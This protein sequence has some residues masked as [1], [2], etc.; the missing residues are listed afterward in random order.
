M[1][2][3]ISSL[4][5]AQATNI[6]KC[7]VRKQLYQNDVFGASCCKDASQPWCNALSSLD[8]KEMLSVLKASA[9]GNKG[10]QHTMNIL[11]EGLTM[12]F[13]STTPFKVSHFTTG[14]PYFEWK[15]LQ[16]TGTLPPIPDELM[17]TLVCP[18]GGV[19]KLDG[20]CGVNFA[21]M[22]DGFVQFMVLFG[23]ADNSLG[24][25]L[26]IRVDSFGN[27]VDILLGIPERDDTT[28][29]I[30][31]NPELPIWATYLGSSYTM[32][33][34]PDS[35]K[36]LP[37]TELPLKLR[38]MVVHM[39]KT[40]TS[41]SGQAY[42]ITLDDPID[43]PSAIAIETLIIDIGLPNVR[44]LFYQTNEFTLP[45]TG[46]MGTQ[47]KTAGRSLDE[48]ILAVDILPTKL[49]VTAATSVEQV[50]SIYNSFRA[51][52]DLPLL[53]W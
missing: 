48:N 22:N 50:K 14:I 32:P 20:N 40:A 41:P 42:N 2:T 49:A 46:F 25:I 15:A 30:V 27:L 23:N 4:L 7:D 10:L 34:S 45:V 6:T 53:H 26:I 44:M 47:P 38:D 28:G 1:F 51:L 43:V 13:G 29:Q 3:L 12:W 39:F 5:L 17:P 18:P 8:Q 35:S 19:E 24:I 9:Q 16:D 11:E 33:G 21:R 36:V 37:M 52:L 31:T